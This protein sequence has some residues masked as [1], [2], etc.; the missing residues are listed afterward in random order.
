MKIIDLHGQKEFSAT[1]HIHETL[2]ATPQ[3]SQ[4]NLPSAQ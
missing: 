3:R 1:H 4:A 2:T